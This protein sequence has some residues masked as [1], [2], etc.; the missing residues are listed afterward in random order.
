MA[1][2]VTLAD[3][4]VARWPAYRLEDAELLLDARAYTRDLGM[5]TAM[6]VWR[7][8]RVDLPRCELTLDGQ[9]VRE[10]W[11][12][13]RGASHP[14]LCT[15]AALAPPCEWLLR[16]GYV[17]CEP[18]PPAPMRVEAS[19]HCVVVRK[20]LA[21]RGFDDGDAAGCVAVTLCAAG[22][23]LLLTVRAEPA[24][25]RLENICLVP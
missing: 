13:G 10:A 7:Q 24:A 19:R 4:C 15:Q 1:R 2:L 14:A 3:A 16:S 5:P 23:H 9:P 17:A 21:L 11:R 22:A 6:A 12:V 18:R 25:G 20:R 8:L